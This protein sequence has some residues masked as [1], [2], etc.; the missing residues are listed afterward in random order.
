MPLFFRR[1]RR[2]ANG[3]RNSL[4]VVPQL[5]EALES[6]LF[7]DATVTLAKGGPT[8]MNF[9]DADGSKSSVSLGGAGTVIIQLTGELTQ[10]TKGKTV[11]VSGTAQNVSL[12][13]NGTTTKTSLTIKGNGGAND[14]AD[15]NG[16]VVAGSLS[17]LK[18][19]TAAIAG[20]LNVAGA[21]GNVSLDSNTTGSVTAQSMLKLTV[22]NAF[23]TDL[24]T[25]A[26]KSFKGGSIVG[27]TWNVGDA[28]SSITADSIT[29]WTAN[30]DTLSKL[31]VKD[32]MTG[33]TLRAAGNIGTVQ[34]GNLAASNVYAG[35]ANLAPGTLP[36]SAAD[37]S[38]P[39]VI[40]T[41]KLKGLSAGSNVAA[42][43]IGTATL[44]T[45]E[46]LAP[47]LPRFGLGSSQIKSLTATVSGNKLKLKKVT[48]QSE[49]DSALAAEAIPPQAFVILIV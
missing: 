15:V 20:N 43:S 41:L 23:T 6:R 48:A 47:T 46:F 33:S 37:F 9:T 45:V 29:G 8:K 49:V 42:S 12:L 7:M 1:P 31:S 34:V 3:S 44:G 40:N 2:G 25:S 19:K 13:A 17:A 21:A 4:T 14:R 18:A 36:G 24:T 28:T 5:P 11:D 27:G 10:A 38:A 22:T 26:L 16:V 32:A 35:L 30:L 39:A